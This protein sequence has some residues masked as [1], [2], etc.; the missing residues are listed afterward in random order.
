MS[1]SEQ[2][3]T[4]ILTPFNLE[5]KMGFKN[6]S[7]MGGFDRYVQSNLSPALEH[8]EL[9]Q[10][11][12]QK[13]KSL[14]SV[15]SE[16]SVQSRKRIL[17]GLYNILTNKEIV[18]KATSVKTIID[19]KVNQSS[20]KSIK[21]DIQF[22]KGVGPQLA[23]KMKT[24][25][26]YTIEDLLYL[27]PRRYEDRGNL[28]SIS[29]TQDGIF[30][31][32]K[33]RVVNKKEAKI[34]KGLTISKIFIDDGTGFAVLSYFNQPFRFKSIKIGDF[35]YVSGKVERK[36]NEV[37][38]Q[39]PDTENINDE[40]NINTQRIIPIYPSTENLSQKTIRRIIKTA[41]EDYANL[42][43][44]K[45]PKALIDKYKFLSITD[46][47][48]QLHFP[49]SEQLRIKAVSRLIYEEFFYMQL[50]ILSLRQNRIVRKKEHTYNL[51]KSILEEFEQSLPFKLTAAQKRVVLEVMMDLASSS[52]MSRLVQGDVGSGKTIV[53]AICI[54]IAV[55]SGFQGAIM[56]PT[57]IL[58]EQH[59]KKFCQYLEPYGIKTALFVGGLPKKERDALREELKNGD[60]DV[61]VG[62]H[63]LIQEGIDFKN[64]SFC[65]VDEQHRFGVMQRTAL[66][67]KG[68]DPDL[69]VMTATPIPRTLSLIIYGDLNISIIDE[70]PPGRQEIKSYFRP[71][72]KIDSVYS[73]VKEEI[74]KGRQAYIVCPLVDESDKIEAKSAIAHAQE[75]KNGIFSQLCTEVL[76]GKMK[77]IEKD[78]IMERFRKGKTNILIST[79]VIEVGVDVP[80]AT[81]MVI[82][83][84]E[85]FGLA[86]LHQLRGR[87][88]RG[89][90]QSYC[91]FTGDIKSAEGRER[92]ETITGSSDGF[93]I[94]EKD[95][96]LRGPGDFCGTRQ[97]GLPDMR[98][99]DII[100]DAKIL[101]YARTD[102]M[103]T[104]DQNPNFAENKKLE[105]EIHIN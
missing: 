96:K 30:H 76:H 51:N 9:T 34:R 66:Q 77:S 15:Y 36:F 101:E 93:V 10:E 45:L 22:A 38:F 12:F 26:I 95:L 8:E 58:A 57:E 56:A 84:A 55:K 39:N 91:F 72:S 79:T 5:E 32:V 85:R 50:S 40:E 42:L 74:K 35:L 54:Y 3:L 75:L 11:Q 73:F 28:I 37:Q 47:L 98:I 71:I 44:D 25:G 27:V 97:S 89:S 17:H 67:Q 33:G 29:Q 81:V 70:L 69:L 18:K 83:N 100:R 16:S 23:V 19:N 49:E 60:I 48:K 103:E 68:G 59:Y 21:S 99:A 104:L 90:H 13:A 61:A 1:K 94:A 52:P 64:L 87:V 46:T 105:T 14:I 20:K 82:L 86:Q 41:F 80:N 4:L 31:T 43:I 62:T 102:A 2:F 53:A 7:V 63:A 6:L 65:V 24:L 78:E 92:M 88:G